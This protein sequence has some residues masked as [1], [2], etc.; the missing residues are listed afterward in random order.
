MSRVQEQPDRHLSQGSPYTLD[1][2]QTLMQLPGHSSL[3][4]IMAA[5][6][7]CSDGHRLSLVQ[8]AKLTHSHVVRT[9]LLQPTGSMG[10]IRRC[11]LC[12]CCQAANH[13]YF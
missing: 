10:Q 11:R 8:G 12:L 6:V 3:Q 1:L 13:L 9:E 2:Q 7:L 4:A 5:L